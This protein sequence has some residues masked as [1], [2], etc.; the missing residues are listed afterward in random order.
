MKKLILLVFLVVGVTAQ[1]QEKAKI[2]DC[3]QPVY[4]DDPNFQQGAEKFFDILS[5][6]GKFEVKYTSGDLRSQTI[7]L[8]ANNTSG[9]FSL[10]EGSFYSTWSTQGR[11]DIVLRDFGTRWRG[12]L[13]FPNGFQSGILNLPA[14]AEIDLACVLKPDAK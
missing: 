1:A 14:G 13:M 3:M 7:L 9:Y 12:A 2:L 10:E 8:S 5:V 11:V 6:D 4:L